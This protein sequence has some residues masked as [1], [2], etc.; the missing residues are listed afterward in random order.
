MR[1]ILALLS[2]LASLLTNWQNSQLAEL[3]ARY[4]TAVKRAQALDARLTEHV[5]AKETLEA[6][7]AALRN[8]RESLVQQ[9]KDS[10]AHIQKLENDLEREKTVIVAMPSDDVWNKRIGANITPPIGNTDA[11]N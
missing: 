1:F 4:G 11:F 3:D 7:N 6:E 10:N 9:V 8:Q 5:K 2:K